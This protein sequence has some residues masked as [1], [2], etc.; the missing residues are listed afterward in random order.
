MVKDS[1]QHPARPEEGEMLRDATAR[2]KSMAVIAPNIDK[3]KIALTQ[4]L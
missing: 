3:L 1:W 4:R 2:G